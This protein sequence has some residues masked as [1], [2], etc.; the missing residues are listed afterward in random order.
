MAPAR[1]HLGFMDLHGGLGRSFGSLGLT[2]STLATV[3]AAEA[4]ATLAVEG[5]EAARALRVAERLA[6]RH[7]T[8]CGAKITVRQAIPAHVGLGSGTQLA[9]AVGTALA[10]LH[11]W[12]ATPRGIAAVAARG[13]RSGIGIGAFETGGFLVDGGKGA[14]DALPQIIARSDFPEAWRILLIFDRR[15]AGIHGSSEATAFAALPRFPAEAAAGLCRLVMMQLLPALAAADLDRFGEAVGTL[16]RVV[17]DHFAPAQGGRF[18][19]PAVSAVLAWLA[20]EGIAGIGQ[21]SWGPTGFAI[22]ADEQQGQVLLR[23]AARRWGERGELSFMLCAG[24]NRGAVIEQ[25][26]GAAATEHRWL[27]A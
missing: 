18:T 10:A 11:G 3:V 8:S 5:P 16:Q 21:S 22:V 20:G 26:A 12:P 23:R 25:T 9:L 7:G 14:D 4:A 17:G 27:V 1:L 19:S 13:A 24:R 15:R 2:V 6:A